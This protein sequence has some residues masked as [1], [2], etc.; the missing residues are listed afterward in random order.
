MNNTTNNQTI[1]IKQSSVAKIFRELEEKNLNVYKERKQTGTLRDVIKFNTFR[2]GLNGI[3]HELENGDLIFIQYMQSNT[4]KDSPYLKLVDSPNFSYLTGTRS[5]MEV[6]SE[7]E[8]LTKLAIV[9]LVCAVL[10]KED[11][12]PILN[13]QQYTFIMRR[14]NEGVAEDAWVCITLDF[15]INPTEWK[16]FFNEFLKCTEI[17]DKYDTIDNQTNAQQETEEQSEQTETK[18]SQEN[19]DM[20]KEQMKNAKENAEDI[21]LNSE[22][23]STLKKVLIGTGAAVVLGG[24]GYLVYKNFIKG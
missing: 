16:R 8:L 11:P 6:V 1:S 15:Q 4:D 9:S 19:D 3:R 13:K 21:K 23:M 18:P 22:G 10:Q 17:L 24:A 7:I 5:T 2:A 20:N 12:E 14:V